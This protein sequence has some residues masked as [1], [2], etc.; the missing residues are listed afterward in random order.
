VRNSSASVS[1]H[2]DERISLLHEKSA[3]RVQRLETIARHAESILAPKK[4]EH[5]LR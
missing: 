3:A 2:Q 1:A 4:V 5:V